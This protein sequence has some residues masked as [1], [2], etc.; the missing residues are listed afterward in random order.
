MGV[1]RV[2]LTLGESRTTAVGTRAAR[3]LHH[4]TGEQPT[5]IR[6][7]I[8]SSGFFFI[9]YFL[10]F[11]AELLPYSEQ[12]IARNTRRGRRPCFSIA[13]DA[14]V[15]HLSRQGTRVLSDANFVTQLAWSATVAGLLP[16]W[17]PGP[18]LE[19]SPTTSPYLWSTRS[20]WC[21]PVRPVA[22]VGGCCSARII[23]SDARANI[24]GEVKFY[25]LAQLRGSRS[26][27][28]SQHG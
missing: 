8:R 23:L 3:A 16:N 26:S 24:H 7:S 19:T 18:S 21:H 28:A 13:T 22:A 1:G 6:F 11:F 5:A 15:A 10:A 17:D 4:Y 12:R 14:Y 27:V 2:G 9:H 25:V 20:S